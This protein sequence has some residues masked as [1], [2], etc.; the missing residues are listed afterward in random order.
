VYGDFTIANGDYVF[1]DGVNDR[2]VI[3]NGFSN[4]IKTTWNYPTSGLR[5]V[6]WDG[7]NLMTCDNATARKHV[8]L[9][10]A[11][12]DSFSMPTNVASG[13]AWDENGGNLITAK[14][15]HVVTAYQFDGFS[16]TVLD[17]FSTT[18]GGTSNCVGWYDGNLYLGQ[19]NQIHKM[20]GFSA[21]IDSTVSLFGTVAWGVAFR[22][23]WVTRQITTG[24]GIASS[25]ASGANINGKFGV[26]YRNDSGHLLYTEWDGSS[27]STP[28]TIDTLA[29]AGWCCLAEINGKPGIA[30]TNIGGGAHS[31]RVRY[32]QKN[33]TWS[34][35]D[36]ETTYLSASNISLA[37]ISGQ[38]AI[39]WADSVSNAIR[40][41]R[42]NGSTWDKALVHAAIQIPQYPSL[43]DINGQPAIAW[44]SWD[45]SN[46]RLKY[47]RYTGAS[48]PSPSQIDTGDA[49]VANVGRYAC[50]AE[51][52]GQPA[53][54]HFDSTNTALKYTKFVS[55]WST[56][57]I[58]STGTTGLGGCLIE[59]GSQPSIVYEND[60]EKAIK[61]ATYNGSSWDIQT[62]VTTTDPW[63]AST[64]RHY[65]LIGGEKYTTYRPSVGSR[66]MASTV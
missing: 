56:E 47:T 18:L 57:T 46:Q 29:G 14:A 66:W 11:V 61:I 41:A 63:T 42:F 65:A 16:S 13:L 54:S 36:V 45:T 17:S 39:A 23:G 60:T 55:N 5:G 4:E 24:L 7:A 6:T 58:T 49:G 15:S 2:I 40:Y 27:W 25:Y 30:F 20:V 8:G 31:Q 59:V 38:P 62:I 1:A 32:A 48:W 12:A 34:V 26:A 28:E 43:A 64:D 9:T 51:I 22:K 21:T 37:E 44:Q 33:G 53:V 19:A 10:S 35:T 52:N 50:L 3:M